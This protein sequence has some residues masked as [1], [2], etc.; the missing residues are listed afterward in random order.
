LF[1]SDSKHTQARAAEVKLFSSAAAHKY[2]KWRSSMNA[3]LIAIS[4]SRDQKK[5]RNFCQCRAS[6]VVR[7]LFA[8]RG[9]R[10]ATLERENHYESSSET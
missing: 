8:T 1:L 4:D 2:R 10:A 6:H 3:K 9:L 5:R 7:M